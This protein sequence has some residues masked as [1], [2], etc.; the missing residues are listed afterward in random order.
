[1]RVILGVAVVFG[2]TV[3]ASAQVRAGGSATEEETVKAPSCPMKKVKK[4][5]Y[6]AT[7]DKL[8]VA[9]ED[10]AEKKCAACGEAPEKVEV[11]EVVYYACPKCKRGASKKGKCEVEGCEKA[12]LEET[13]SRV[14]VVWGCP[15]NCQGRSKE[16]IKCEREDCA[17]KG[18]SYEKACGEAGKWPHAEKP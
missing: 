8:L 13:V 17:A 3:P 5:D 10:L 6:C 16:K 1:M 7:C 12:E 9:K 15:G 2:L 18:K 4:V 11:C 14:R